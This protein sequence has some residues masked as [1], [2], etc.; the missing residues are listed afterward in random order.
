MADQVINFPR[1]TTLKHAN[2]IQRA[3]AAGCATPGKIGR[4]SCRERV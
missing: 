2:E 4:A 1:D 3:I